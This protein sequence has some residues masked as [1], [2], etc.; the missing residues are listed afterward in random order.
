MVASPSMLVTTRCGDFNFSLLAQVMTAPMIGCSVALSKISNFTFRCAATG[1]ASISSKPMN[2]T[3]LIVFI[4][5]VILFFQILT[6]FQPRYSLF[7]FPSFF[8]CKKKERYVWA[9]PS[10]FDYMNNIKVILDHFLF[11]TVQGLSHIAQTP[12]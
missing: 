8:T 2:I 10:F 3:F 6:R 7:L 9:Y 11:S 5:I 1:R 4:Y 12:P